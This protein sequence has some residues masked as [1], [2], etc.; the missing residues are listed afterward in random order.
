MSPRPQRAGGRAAVA[1][2]RRFLLAIAPDAGR[3][4]LRPEDAVHALRVLRLGAG[5]RILGL[6]GRGAAWPLAV[7]AVSAGRIEL[8]PAGEPL[9][10][11]R[12]GDAGARLP[13]IEVRVAWPRA[14]RPEAM[15]ERLA[16]LGAMRIVAWVG[17][18]SGPHGRHAGA[19]V[20]RLERVLAE[21][22]KQCG[23][24]WLP[25]LGA[26][27]EGVAPLAAGVA[28]AVLDPAAGDLL[29]DWARAELARGARR[30]CLA[31]GPEGGLSPAELAALGAQGFRAARLGP[32]V[33]RIE[34]AAEAALAIVAHEALR[35]VADA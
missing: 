2:L 7:R 6:D 35:E 31:V 26:P 29:G 27:L 24:L 10:E 9:R 3:P 34:T 4:E 21:A 17:E 18:R 14:G 23:R 19:R 8:E 5:D 25:E 16:Q 28:G 1:P 13:W 11:P 30:L 15:L 33:L 22:C 32:H 20:E 12:P